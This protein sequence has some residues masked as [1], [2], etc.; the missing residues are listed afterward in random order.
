MIRWNTNELLRKISLIFDLIWRKLLN[1]DGFSEWFME[2]KVLILTR[3]LDFICLLQLCPCIYVMREKY[4]NYG[5]FYFKFQ[6]MKFID[7][8][9]QRRGTFLK[10]IKKIPE[11][12][13]KHQ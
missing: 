11:K 5:S 7:G 4:K 10:K 3:F 2:Q 8:A 12:P 13:R 6:N 9:N 1:F